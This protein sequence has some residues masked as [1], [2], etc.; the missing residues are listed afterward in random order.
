MTN[1]LPN[2]HAP[3][4]HLQSTSFPDRVICLEGNDRI[5][6][7][8]S[9]AAAI[10]DAWGDAL[11]FPT[12]PVTKCQAYHRGLRAG[13]GTFDSRGHAPVAAHKP[14]RSGGCCVSAAARRTKDAQAAI[15]S[16][17]GCLRDEQQMTT[18]V[19]PTGTRELAGPMVTARRHARGRR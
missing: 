1:C 4:K 2:N 13:T 7:K 3:K 18:P 9:K 19:R 17:W 5:H 12:E 11:Q 14:A 10:A 16:P 8:R 6:S 15:G